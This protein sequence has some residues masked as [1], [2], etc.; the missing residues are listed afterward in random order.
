[1]QSKIAKAQKF[2][3]KHLKRGIICESW[4]PYVA[5]LFFVKK[6]DGKLQPVQNY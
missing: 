2:I 4:S 1:M 5:N 6:K 3:A